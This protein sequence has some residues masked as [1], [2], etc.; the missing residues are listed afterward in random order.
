MSSIISHHPSLPDP[1]DLIYNVNFHNM[2]AWK[3]LIITTLHLSWHDHIDSSHS[4]RL[5]DIARIALSSFK[6]KSKP[7]PTIS[8][9]KS[10]PSLSFILSYRLRLLLRCSD[11]HGHTY[12]FHTSSSDSPFCQLCP[13]D[14]IES[15]YHFLID[16]NSYAPIRAKWFPIINHDKCTGM[17]LFERIIGISSN[18]HRDLPLQILILHY[19]SDLRAHRTRCL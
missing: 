1:S 3:N 2:K 14:S 8:I 15:S 17:A 18:P 19:I 10:V 6:S 13:T 16:C 4:S 5:T 9:L 11:L 7:I 12:M